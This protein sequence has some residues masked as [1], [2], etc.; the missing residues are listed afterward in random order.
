MSS[1]EELGGD[2]SGRWLG[3]NPLAG[4]CPWVTDP[5]ISSARLTRELTEHQSSKTKLLADGVR[6]L[7]Q[8]G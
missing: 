5:W 8:E 6:T 1:S 7:S 2:G 4:H 3:W